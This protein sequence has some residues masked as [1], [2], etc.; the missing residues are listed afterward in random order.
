[1][2][3]I[4]AVA[5]CALLALTAGA[6]LALGRP[7]VWWP[8]GLEAAVV[9]LALA[10]ERGRYRPRI[11]SASAAFAPTGERFADPTSGQV[12]DVYADP[13]TGERDYRPSA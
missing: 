8:V 10:F 11:T 13:K 9:G 4:I 12:L 6:Q 3:R 7:F 1:M 5:G 2:G